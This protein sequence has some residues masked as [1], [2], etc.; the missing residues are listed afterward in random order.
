MRADRITQ[1]MKNALSEFIMKLESFLDYLATKKLFRL[2]AISICC[3]TAFIFR[4]LV[5]RYKPP[6]PDD[7]PALHAAAQEFIAGNNV[8]AVFG[9]AAYTSKPALHLYLSAA[10]YLTS[11]LVG[12]PHLT[13]THYFLFTFDILTGLV[14]YKIIDNGQFW[15]SFLGLAIWVFN[16]FVLNTSTD[17][18]YE[19]VMLLFLLL[20][21]FWLEKG[22]EIEA[23]V[24]FTISTMIK[25]VPILILPIFLYKTSNR[26][27]NLLI[28]IGLFLVLSLP[29]LLMP[30]E[31]FQSLAYNVVGRG[32]AGHP[33]YGIFGQVNRTYSLIIGAISLCLM[34]LL[35][36]IKFRRFDIYLIGFLVFMVAISFYWITFEQY[37]V[38]SVPFI[39]ITILK[40]LKFKREI[41]DK[42][43]L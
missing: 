31:Y 21:F 16:P 14:I 34:L 5:I 11:T 40:N 36:Y 29:F 33:G 22:N 4:L 27:R 7:F 39:I 26:L 15:N 1:P 35:I 13:I 6:T 8:Y 38:W 32:P 12:V 17:A 18:K 9:T 43:S 10:L 19:V 24:L 23:T 30:F 42:P 2:I 41:D 28:I 37:F 3:V 25:P 20:A